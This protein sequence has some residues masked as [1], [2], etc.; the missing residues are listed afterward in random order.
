M[1][2]M[3]TL[4]LPCNVYPLLQQLF[5]CTAFRGYL[6]SAVFDLV[7]LCCEA[8][9]AAETLESLSSAAGYT[10]TAEIVINVCA[11]SRVISLR[12]FSVQVV[13]FSKQ[14]IFMELYYGVL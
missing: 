7:A 13:R 4:L 5:G 8:R 1:L 12:A 6:Y 9:Y 14:S 10:H 11:F 3:Q 2:G